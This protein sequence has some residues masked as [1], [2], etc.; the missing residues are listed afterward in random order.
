MLVTLHVDLGRQWRGGQSQAL[1]AIEGLRSRNHEAELVALR[2]SPLAERARSAGVTVHEASSSPALLMAAGAIR[3]QQRRASFDVVHCHDANGLTAAWIA[4]AHRRS[5][6]IASR[7]VAYPLSG[8]PLARARYI[9]AAEI[10]A[11][12]RFVAESVIGCGVG[13]DHVAVVYDGVEIPP[14]PSPSERAAARAEWNIPPGAPLLGCVGYLLPEKGQDLLIR[15]LPFI[16]ESQPNARLLLAGAGPC[17]TAL[18][19]LAR[20]LGVTGSVIFAGHVPQVEPVYAAL[21]V[22]VFPSVA[23]PLGSSLLSAM[24]RGTP[25]VAVG[26]GAVPEIITDG[27]DGLLAEPEPSNFAAAAVRVLADISLAAR[28]GAAGRKRIETRFSADRMVEDTLELYRRVCA[29]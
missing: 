4:R 18:E 8:N 11:V 26:R 3:E 14:P 7:R 25:A 16:L 19:E 24:A 27:V 9:S 17:R 23:E 12:S 10:A 15:A 28:L 20:D 6:V 13:E 29:G 2:G 22:F 5:K 1:L 21:D